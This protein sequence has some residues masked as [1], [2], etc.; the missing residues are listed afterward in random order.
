MKK[1]LFV[2]ITTLL[3]LSVLVTAQNVA[4]QDIKVL[5]DK[6]IEH[7]FKVRLKEYFELAFAGKDYR[8]AVLA[9]HL[10]KRRIEYKLLLE[11]QQNLTDNQKSKIDI[12]LNRV[13]ERRERTEKKIEERLNKT[14]E[15]VKILVLAVLQKHQERLQELSAQKPDNVGLKTAVESSS[16]VVDKISENLIQTRIVKDCETQNIMISNLDSE[17]LVRGCKCDSDVDCP[18]NTVCVKNIKTFQLSS[19]ICISQNKCEIGKKYYDGI[20]ECLPCEE[21]KICISVCRSGCA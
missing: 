5:P 8:T 15:E 4:E 1:T 12:Y 20:N 10:E 18:Q 6:P 11:K 14:P 13:E 19:G 17:I 3:T 16:K 7:F 9:T 2:L 21:G